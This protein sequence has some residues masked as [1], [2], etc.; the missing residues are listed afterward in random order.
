[1]YHS[2]GMLNL[3]SDDS[4]TVH[5]WLRQTACSLLCLHSL[6][7]P[8][9]R[10]SNM[11]GERQGC[12]S[13]SRLCMQ[14]AWTEFVTWHAEVSSWS[15]TH[16]FIFCLVSRFGSYGG[17]GEVLDNPPLSTTKQYFGKIQ[18][19]VIHHV[20]A[21]G[22]CWLQSCIDSNASPG[23]QIEFM[24]AIQGPEPYPIPWAALQFIDS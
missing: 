12:N 1:M 23:F 11:N 15:A 18:A 13:S 21:R 2:T 22:S 3:K 24:G 16:L 17:G 10:I 8:I 7:A 6:K 9:D 14:S 5:L 4:S 20:R 19:T